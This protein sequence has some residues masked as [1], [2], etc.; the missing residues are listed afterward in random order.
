MIAIITDL[1]FEV[2]RMGKEVELQEEWAVIG[3]P[4]NTVEVTLRV[5][6]YSDGELV[7]A[8]KKMSMTDVLDAFKLAEDGFTHPDDE[9]SLTDKGLSLAKSFGE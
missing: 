9:W 4:R 1:D 5:R 3:L 7:D 6:M 8:E 2:I